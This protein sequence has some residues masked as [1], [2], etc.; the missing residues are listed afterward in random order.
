M[1]I[2]QLLADN[3]L[4]FQSIFPYLMGLYGVTVLTFLFRSIP[5]RIIALI[6]KHCTTTLTFTSDLSDFFMWIMKTF[7]EE[8]LISTAR[9]LRFFARPWKEKLQKGIGVGKQIFIFRDKIIWI[10]Y[11]ID[12]LV[13]GQL[14]KIS[15]T[16]LGRDQA[17]FDS[18]RNEF[19]HNIGKE[20]SETDETAVYI[21][22]DGWKRECEIK[23]RSFDTIFLDTN[24]KKKLTNHLDKFYA[25][26]NWYGKRGI[27]YQTGILLYG[28]PGSGKTSIVRSLAGKYNKRL[29]IIPAAQ[30]TELPKALRS[31]PSDSFVVI[32]DIDINMKV[33]RREESLETTE[34]PDDTSSQVSLS[35]ILNALDGIISVPGRVL[36]LT[37]NHIEVLDKAFIRPGRIDLLVD[38]SYA[39]VEA[40]KDFVKV[41][42][43]ESLEPNTLALLDRV[44]QIQNVTIAQL[45]ND[46]MCGI[47]VERLI[48]KYCIPCTEHYTI[49]ANDALAK[50]AV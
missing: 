15:I 4:S 8:S 29:C 14:H 41:F 25:N 13:I 31:L 9:S 27:S 32:E 24:T 12:L 44:R 10:S 40:F 7:E 2:S 38:I 21:F 30:L 45:Q 48:Q 26:E 11:T 23:K 28:E 35:E 22:H 18:L 39:S 42:Y 6:T 17:F 47:V 3:Q 37:T 19:E 20:I 5:S 49:Q 16:I 50:I 36:F 33:H 1:N 34:H 43:A 46:F